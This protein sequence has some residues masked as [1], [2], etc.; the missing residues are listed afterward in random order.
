MKKTFTL[1]LLVI[2]SLVSFGQNQPTA[3]STVVISQ[4]YGGGGAGTGSP[5]YFYDYV[6]LHN[7]SGSA[8]DLKGY[9][10]QYGSATGN[11]GSSASNIFVFTQTAIIPAGGYL[12]IQT[13]SAGSL[14][15]PF[16]VTPDSTTTKLNMSATS[17]KVALSNDSTALGCG[18]TATPCT[19]PNVK[20]VDVVAYGTSNDGEGGTTVNNGVALNN[21]QGA[22]RNNNGCTDTDNNNADFTVVASPNLI[23]RNSAT[24][25]VTCTA[26]PIFL[27]SFTAFKGTATNKLTWKVECQSNSVRFELERSSNHGSFETIYTYTAT[28]AE[29][30]QAFSFEEKP[31][32]GA[33][34]YRLKIVDADNVSRYSEIKMLVNK[35][36]GLQVI[37]IVPTVVKDYA[38]YIIASS[39]A[40][41]LDWAI[42]NMQGQTIAKGNSAVAVGENRI[43][44]NTATLPAGTYKLLGYNAGEK[45]PA[46]TLIKL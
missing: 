19:L 14:G 10:I 7:V 17:G 46:T 30:S 33:N 3:S 15:N 9:S 39:I 21:T 35:S 26:L 25:P 1:V 18:A 31:I 22:V 16:P 6:E 45:T 44:I 27:Q 34:Y 23:P 4:V 2:A 37:G 40:T 11:F 29:C 12:L 24:A 36:S 5:A 8:I 32:T 41:R 28:K 20:I 43:R 42:T 13:G 38:D